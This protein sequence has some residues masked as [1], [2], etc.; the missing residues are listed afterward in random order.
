MGQL[1]DN[2]KL[3]WST[4]LG[5]LALLWCYT[6]A[7]QAAPGDIDT[8]AGGYIG[9]GQQATVAKLSYPASV[10]VDATGNLYIAGWAA[11]RIR[12]VDGTTSVITTI[13]GNGSFGYS[14]DGGPATA[15][16]LAAPESV[17]LD[18]AGNL[19]FSEWGNHIIRRVDSGT[20]VITTVAGSGT[21][22]Y[23]G[24]GGP[25]TAAQLDTPEGVAVDIAGNL[26]IADSNNNRIRRVD[27]TTGIITTIT[28]NGTWGFS[29][30][31]GLATAA[32][33]GTSRGI[34]V[35]AAGNLYIADS[36]N[37]RIRR[38]DATTGIITT[39]A[40]GGFNGD[41]ALATTAQLQWPAGVAVDAAGNLYIG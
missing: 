40:G 24:D 19:Y 8:V 10:A 33:L 22:G 23:S 17:V 13:A 12:R 30:D 15:A 18:G 34:A 20:G 6:S 39:V 14:G 36:S 2:K 5:F 38:V 3:L 28:G 41:G 31:G 29:G 9:D 11:H 25:A 4:W 37:G 27:G 32:T 1:A 7:A 21:A 35:D 26:Y 16:A